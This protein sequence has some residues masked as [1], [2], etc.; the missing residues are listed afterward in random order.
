MVVEIRIVQDWDADE[1]ITKLVMR[2]DELHKKGLKTDVK[3]STAIGSDDKTLYSAMIIVS[4][5]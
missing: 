3:F 1:F 2:L 5:N 4:R